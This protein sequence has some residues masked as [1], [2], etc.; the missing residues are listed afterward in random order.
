MNDPLQDYPSLGDPSLGVDLAQ[1]PHPSFDSSGLHHD[2]HHHHH[3][4]HHLHNDH[5]NHH[6]SVQELPSHHDHLNHD[7]LDHHSHSHEPGQPHD[8]NDHDNRD[9]NH[10]SIDL[11]M[12]EMQRA[13]EQHHPSFER[14]LQQ[15]QD[16]HNRQQQQQQQQQDQENGVVRADEDNQQKQ[17]RQ[18]QQQHLA[19]HHEDGS[20]SLPEGTFI[21]LEDDSGSGSHVDLEGHHSLDLNGQADQV[22]STTIDGELDLEE[23][24]GRGGGGLGGGLGGAGAGGKKKRPKYGINQ[25]EDRLAKIRAQ[26]RERQRRKRERDRAQKSQDP[27]LILQDASQPQA[28]TSTAHGTLANRRMGLTRPGSHSG[29]GVVGDNSAQAS[30]NAARKKRKPNQTGQSDLSQHYSA[31]GSPSPGPSAGGYQSSSRSARSSSTTQHILDLSAAL[32]LHSNSTN[33]T[34]TN[35]SSGGGDHHHHQNHIQQ[36]HH[37]HHPS[38]SPISTGPTPN[39]HLFAS[40]LLLALQMND[41]LKDHLQRTLGVMETDYENMRAGIGEVFDRYVDDHNAR[42]AAA[43]VAVALAEATGGEGSDADRV[44]D[45]G[46][47]PEAEGILRMDIGALSSREGSELGDRRESGKDSL[48]PTDLQITTTNSF[49]HVPNPSSIDPPSIPPSPPPLPLTREARTPSDSPPDHH[50]TSS[51]PSPNRVSFDHSKPSVRS[52]S[53]LFSVDPERDLGRGTDLDRDPDA[54][55]AHPVQFTLS[56][57]DG[58]HHFSFGPDDLEDHSSVVAT[59]QHLQQLQFQQLQQEA[60]VSPVGEAVV[61]GNESW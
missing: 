11:P 40:T 5:V 39:G 26:G 12:E 50:S 37:H 22:D 2:H 3:H 16:A 8:E 59:L 1:D 49:D 44:Q 7:H 58:P 14:Q 55:N 43:A 18:R 6:E 38:E 41:G 15:L 4:H 54:S 25:D 46:G 32:S 47:E 23:G 56:L 48:E 42:A 19:Y 24:G 17:Q 10:Q 33:G 61:G 52:L 29:V 36:H 35:I 20:I 57:D 51:L 60:G 45:E 34:G 9:E 27:S 53:P 28:S 21:H 13:L 31:H 30:A